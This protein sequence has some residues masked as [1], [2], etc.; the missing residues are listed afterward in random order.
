MRSSLAPIEALPFE[1]PAHTF[2]ETRP[3]LQLVPGYLGDATPTPPLGN[4]S[5]VLA[6]DIFI[7]ADTIPELAE[8]R[9]AAAQNAA[10]ILGQN[11]HLLQTSGPEHVPTPVDALGTA[12]QVIDIKQQHGITSPEYREVFTGL[13]LDSERLLAEAFSKNTSEYFAKVSQRFD[14]NSEEYFAHRLSIS[15]M[16]TNGLSP[17]AETEEQDRRVNEY[18]EEKGTYEAIGK[19]IGKVGLQATIDLLAKPAEIEPKKSGL[20]VTTVSECTDYAIRDYQINPKAS[21]GGYAPAVEKLMIR[22][23]HFADDSGDRMEEQVAVPGIYINH[24]LIEDVLAGKGGIEQ[25]QHLDKTQLHG[26]QFVGVNGEGVMSFVRD[27]DQKASEV[28]GKNIFMGEEVAADHPKDYAEFEA[29]AEVRRQK[30]APKPTELAELLIDLAENGTDSRVAEGLVDLFLKKTLLEVA[31]KHPEL[32]EAM[33]D[34]ATAEGF[35]E[36][37]RLEAQGRDKEA[38][39]LQFLVEENAP[40]VSY[41]GAGS[42]GLEGVDPSSTD[43]QIAVRLGLRGKMVRNKNNACT[44]CKEFSLHHDYNGNTVCTSCKSTKMSGQK[45]KHGKVRSLD[46]QR[47]KSKKADKRKKAPLPE[48]AGEIKPFPRKKP[49]NPTPA[50]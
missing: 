48:K 2:P 22:R 7:S 11:R 9:Q 32:A 4:L 33:F 50:A 46:E 12:R 29:E 6:H 19:L 15:K 20:H 40:E 36:V 47:E 17:S 43:G 28:H 34:K 42:C 35:A 27:L 41:C 30:L 26:T 25:T 18:V 8:E 16:V 10:R 1:A 3:D 49:K 24:D 45:V 31:K 13:M 5:L 23:V 37:A 44:N 21:H 14:R 38:R 39:E